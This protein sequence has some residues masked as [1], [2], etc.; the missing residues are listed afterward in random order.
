MNK[1][2]AT[3]HSKKK[4]SLILSSLLTDPDDNGA[5]SSG[6]IRHLFIARE[7]NDCEK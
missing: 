7:V 2:A 6:L 3:F 4:I 1:A 5:G